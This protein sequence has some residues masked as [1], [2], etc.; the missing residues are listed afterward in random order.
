MAVKVWGDEYYQRVESIDGYS[1]IR[2]EYGWICYADLSADGDEFVATD[3]V[4]DGV[5]L[6]Q[7]PDIKQYLHESRNLKKGLKINHASRMKKLKKRKDQLSKQ[8]RRDIFLAP[9]QA[10]EAVE[11]DIAA[12]FAPLAGTVVGL[13][14]LV[15]FPDE[16]SSITTTQ[17]NNYCNQIGYSED[18][19]NGS[20]YDYFYDVSNGL[21]NY[22]NIVVGYYTAA[23]NKD[24]YNDT[25]RPLG[26]AARE[27]LDEALNWLEG[28]SFDFEQLTTATDWN[29]DE[30]IVATNIFYAGYPDVGWAEGLWPHA[31]A[32]YGFTSSS[33]GIKSGS[34]Q[35]TDLGSV[36]TLFTFC[37]ENGHMI[38]DFPD[39]YD[40]GYESDGIGDFG[41]MAGGGSPLNPVPPNPYLRDL[42]GW[43]TIIEI[44]G[45]APGTERT[46][47]ANSFTTYRYSHPTNAEE[48]FLIESRLQNGRN[49]YFP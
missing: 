10:A 30:R 31:S 8:N 20:V 13:T 27:L 36:L 9:D 21:L 43:E 47:Q 40:Y 18:F 4:Y 19:N 48:Y 35:I 44:N 34:Y 45:D 33:S 16:S 39:L 12:S 41:L 3:I 23:N 14:I 25:S 11:A 28:Q 22:T 49:Q 7:I 42:K 6:D 26:E 38:C 17:V 32:Y 24:Y 2:N 29:G 1:L 5:N 37:H 46:H 15:D